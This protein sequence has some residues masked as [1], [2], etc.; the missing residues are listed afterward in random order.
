MQLPKWAYIGL[1]GLAI[2]GAGYFYGRA[3][4]AE[5]QLQKQY[6]KPS[7][8]A[9]A[10]ETPRA[11]STLV[12]YTPTAK[13][14]APQLTNTPAPRATATSTTKPTA[15]PILLGRVEGLIRTK[16]WSLEGRNVRLSQYGA[17]VREIKYVLVNTMN[18][19]IFDNVPADEGYFVQI[20][21]IDLGPLGPCSDPKPFSVKP[22]QKTYVYI[23]CRR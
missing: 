23:D 9:M 5:S 18:E 10:Y 8:A 2:V 1:L 16:G 14:T 20:D 21:G 12:P 3:Q 4:Y 11:T 22:S 7:I 15:T 19:F 13:P 17:T 6:V